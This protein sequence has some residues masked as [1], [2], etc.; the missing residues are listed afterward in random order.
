MKYKGILYSIYHWLASIPPKV[1]FRTKDPLTPEE[2]KEIIKE[3][4]RKYRQE[5]KEEIYEKKKQYME[6]NKEHMREKKK[7]WAEANKEKLKEKR[8]LNNEYS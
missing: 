2:K 3:Q 8:R 6:A 7:A 4:M 5:H 1:Q